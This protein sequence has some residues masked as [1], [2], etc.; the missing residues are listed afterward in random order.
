MDISEIA[1]KIAAETDLVLGESIWLHNIPESDQEGVAIKLIRQ[2]KDFGK[3]NI[4]QIVIFVVYRNW[5]SQKS[6]IAQIEDLI[7]NLRGLTS[8]SWSVSG[9]IQTPYYGID[10]H[11]RYVSA[12]MFNIKGGHDV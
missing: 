7:S 8:A 4:Y 10:E 11:K 2:T 9:D 3:V 5:A 12:I 1:I 6:Y